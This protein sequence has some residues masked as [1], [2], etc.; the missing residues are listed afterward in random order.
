MVS[1]F[2]HIDY[3]SFLAAWYQEAKTRSKGISYRSIAKRVGYASPGFF[4]QIL[5]GKTSM[6]HTK[7]EGFAD[8][9]GLKG[10]AREYFLTLVVLNQ[11]KDKS[12]SDRAFAKLKTFREFPIRKLQAGQ[13][14]FL[15]AWHHVAVRELLGIRPFRG[16]YEALARSLEPPLDAQTARESVELLLELGLAVRTPRGIISR[17]NALGAGHVLPGTSTLEFFR[18]LHD[19]GGQAIDRFPKCDKNLSWVTLSVS[20]ETL[21]EILEELRLFRARALELASRD[22]HPTRVHQ[23]TIL[24]HPLSKPILPEASP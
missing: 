1:V 13:E 9:V 3:R 14:R 5:Q 21:K 19:L 16:D 24:L 8:L 17:E 10:R 4:T 23:L 18:K 12:A 20:D 22:D 7:A 2:D 15:G 11:A 6:S